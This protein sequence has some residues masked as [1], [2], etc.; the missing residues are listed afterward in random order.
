MCARYRLGNPAMATYALFGTVALGPLSQIPGSPAKW[1][2]TLVVV[3]LGGVAL[4]TL[5]IPLSVTNWSAALGM[6][7]PGPRTVRV[8]LAISGRVRAVGFRT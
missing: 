3:A 5:G 2:R 4:V 1:A 7:A 6:F 8:L